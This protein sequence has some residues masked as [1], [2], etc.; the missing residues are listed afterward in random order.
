MGNFL[1]LLSFSLCGVVAACLSTSPVS[2]WAQNEVTPYYLT[3][4]ATPAV[5]AGGTVYRF[6]ANASD[7]TDKISA[8]F[9]TDEYNLV[10]NTP[11]G[12]FNSAFN[13]SWSAS[14][15]NPAFLAVV[16]DLA[17]DSY[18]TIGLTG[19]ASLSGLEG[20]SDPSIVEDPMLTPVPSDYF[21]S[22]G[23]ALNVNTLTGA[24][25]Y[26]LNTAA[27][28]LPDADGRWLLMQVTTT[29]SISGQINYQIFP[30]GVGADQLQISLEFDGA[31]DFGVQPQ[32]GCTDPAA[33]NYD[34]F[35][36]S[37][38]GSCDYSSCFGCT[39]PAACNYDSE[40]TVPLNG[41][42]QY[43]D[44]GASSSYTMTVVAEE[45]VQ[46]GLTRYKFYV[47]ML[48]PL[49]QISA[50]YGNADTAMNVSAP[51]GAFNT[52]FNASWSASGINPAF[53]GIAPEMAD[54]SYATIGLEVAASASGITDASDPTL[55]ED[56][57][58]PISP[59]FLEDGAT[60][61][62]A[63]MVVGSSWFVLSDAGNALPND[64]L[65][66]LIMQVT[67]SG[68]VDA[69]LNVQVF[70]QGE[71]TN[72][73][74]KTFIVSGPGTYAAVGDGNACG[75]T[76][77]ASCNFDINATYDDGS[78]LML[79]ECG[80]CGGEG[81]PEGECDCDGNQLDALGVCGG[82]CAADDDADGVCDDVDDCVGAFDACG[83]CNGNDLGCQGC[84]D[85][86]ACNYNP[87]ALFQDGSCLYL[88]NCGICGG[89][90]SSCNDCVDYNENGLCDGDE[91]V[92][93]TYP[94]ATNYNDEAS[95][96]N[97]TCEFS[98]AADINGDGAIQLNDLL[99]LLSAYGT[100][101]GECPDSDQD[102]ICDYADTCI[103]EEDACGVCNGDGLSCLGCTDSE[104]C[105]FDAS[106]TIDDGSCTYISAEACDCDGSVLDECGVC[107][108]AGI[109]EGACDCEGN[110]ED[111]LSVCG[112]DCPLDANND[113]VCD[114]EQE[115]GC[116]YPAA[117][118][119]NPYAAFEDGSCDFFGCVIAGCT[120]PESC[121]YDPEATNEDGSCSY[122]GCIDPY[123]CNFDGDAGCDD[124]SCT[125][126][127]CVDASACNYDAAAGCDDGTCTYGGCI[128]F[129]A[130][131]YDETAGCDD[132]SCIYDGCTD[133][134][135]CNFNE[136]ASI[137]D[138]S[139]AYPG[140]QDA[141]ACN[142]DGAAGCDDGSCTYPG[143][144][145]ETA[146]NY[147]ETAGCDD[148]SCIYEGCTY[149]LA[150][151]YNPIASLDDGSCE[152]GTCPGC[153]DPT[154]CNF[155][156]T[157]T[158]DDG[159]CSYGINGDCTF[160]NPGVEQWNLNGPQ[161][162][163]A[164][165]QDILLFYNTS[166]PDR[167]ATCS[168]NFNMTEG[169]SQISFN[170]IGGNATI[171]NYELETPDGNEGLHLQYS[172]DGSSWLDFPFD[173]LE[174]GNVGCPYANC[175]NNEIQWNSGPEVYTWDLPSSPTVSFRWFQLTT[176]NDCCD[177][178][179]IKNFGVSE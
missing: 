68:M 176:D 144:T 102:G 95:L 138:G 45:A 163:D 54:D 79:D 167:S 174:P 130:F 101:C 128:D 173:D 71:G 117:C 160:F 162:I 145:D 23:E 179:A 99:D 143:C 131:N 110:V 105:N 169:V 107:G 150:C 60:S 158:E 3:V 136:I 129:S 52:D 2:A 152:F 125:Y 156:P 80:V 171:G 121:D 58:Q 111:A 41:I 170:V 51:E 94:D 35:V 76:D 30:L 142:F 149:V 50:V 127:G 119:Y 146:L 96:D 134:T 57:A 137:D 74:Y 120:D 69:T 19:P 14:G 49:D 148:G 97:G 18:A 135:A 61:F 116:T 4:E 36:M 151:N 83:D 139:C 89:N 32:S 109:A 39:D 15:I 16:P 81:I 77:P 178:W 44:C 20:A 29:G 164:D 9:G 124:G 37:D 114:T 165:S 106:S 100:S 75:C 25:W 166:N 17:D 133:A 21:I 66:C 22:G 5:G 132:G 154:A 84:T 91:T 48:D 24:S 103:G 177:H 147:D 126:P 10:L 63:D 59:F 73:A 92:G 53:F 1:H 168:L 157:L 78:C 155:N 90:G 31:G 88:D 112:G 175:S 47:N 42:C 93:C 70:E 46:P 123:A 140:C 12:I 98:C 115:T 86:E 26:V 161:W 172:L 8:V 7:A 65:Q 33:C 64:D 6:Y 72:P 104:A 108:G 56:P 13:A 43:C 38:D 28:A 34:P 118:N 67:S 87:E 62:V 27:N 82:D 141:E 11:E 40:A 153:T 85:D 113:G 159:S 55:V 122:A